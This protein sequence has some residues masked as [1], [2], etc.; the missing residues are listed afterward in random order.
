M[1]LTS[2]FAV[3]ITVWVL[4]RASGCS[5]SGKRMIAEEHQEDTQKKKKI[6]EDELNKV[7]IE[8]DDEDE[9]E[10]SE[11]EKRERRKFVIKYD[12]YNREYAEIPMFKTKSG[13]FEV[14]IR[15]NGLELDFVFDTG[16]S[17]I[18]ISELEYKLLVKKNKIK[19]SDIKGKAI[20]KDASGN[21]SEATKIVLRRVELGNK[22]LNDVEALVV[23][24]S[25][26]P[27]LLG[28]SALSRFGKVEIDY[29]TKVIRLF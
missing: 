3:L 14:P 21:T 10:E 11:D 6:K 20:Y 22:V 19:E 25:R 8:K 9:P 7:V 2:I 27:L 16:A 4:N 1:R 5:K 15:I 17:E 29:D 28:Q 24:N 23:P 26:A 12:E 18:A 13:V